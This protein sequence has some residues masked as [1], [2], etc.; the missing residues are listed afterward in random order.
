MAISVGDLY[1]QACE[2]KD[3]T[4]SGTIL[5]LLANLYSETKTCRAFERVEK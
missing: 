4:K 2:S 1:G 5:K 3:K